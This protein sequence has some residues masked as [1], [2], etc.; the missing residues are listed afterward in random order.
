ME[1]EASAE[2][3][4]G[5][6]SNDDE[7]DTALQKLRAQLEEE[8]ETSRRLSTELAQEIE[9]H[10]RALSLLEE[11][12][13]SREEERQERGSQLRDLQTQLDLVQTQC[14][15]MQQFK[16]E[17]ESLNRE[18]QEL[19]QKL[20]A[21]EDAERR[22]CEAVQASSEEIRRLKEELEEGQE[23]FRQ[24]LDAREVRL[25]DSKNRHNQA[26]AG[27][28]CDEG[29]NADSSNVE[30]EFGQNS[31]NVPISG[32][33]LMERYLS[34]ALPE[35]S[36]YLSANDSFEHSSQ[37]DAS[38]DNRFAKPLFF[39]FSLLTSLQASLNFYLSVF[40][41][42]SF[43][44]NSEVLGDEPLLSISNRFPEGSDGLCDNLS[45]RESLGVSE[46]SSSNLQYVTQWNHGSTLGE[47]D[48]S[49]LSEQQIEGTDLEK[50]LLNQQCRELREEL[51][52]KDRDLNVLREEVVQNEEELEEARSR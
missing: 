7:T 41:F 40:R 2:L 45:P 10:R 44:L 27:L 52:V 49:K 51:D 33:A 28:G 38:A 3:E 25:K 12:R 24:M 15:E 48:M 8:Q 39:P 29:F 14:L 4:C 18:V 13:K 21:K 37:V 47:Q 36:H 30:S 43:E 6:Q 1:K 23:V 16:A 26:K 32:E 5:F 20:Q 17:K 9:K 35:R 31:I 42:Y 11:E 19:T 50:E 22:L 46:A 34:A